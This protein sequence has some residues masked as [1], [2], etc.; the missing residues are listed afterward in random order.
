MS[1]SACS[2]EIL[3]KS[4]T[5]WEASKQAY[6]YATSG[7]LTKEGLGNERTFI[8][9]RGGYLIRGNGPGQGPRV[10]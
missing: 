8:S 4:A 10:G 9:E 6:A 3:S 7:E 2:T 5:V 1:L